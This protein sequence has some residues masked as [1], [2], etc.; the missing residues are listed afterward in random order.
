MTIPD[1]LLRLLRAIGDN[2]CMDSRPEDTGAAETGAVDGQGQEWAD[3]E[4]LAWPSRRVIDRL[5]GVDLLECGHP[6]PAAPGAG[7]A[8]AAP[9]HRPCPACHAAASRDPQEEVRAHREFLTR[10]GARR[11]S[12][13]A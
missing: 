7:S 11:P 6:L 9:H 8:P 5:D 3:P 2:R 10:F 4:D 12:E 13:G 1:L